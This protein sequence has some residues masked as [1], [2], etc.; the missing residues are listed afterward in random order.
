MHTVKLMIAGASSALFLLSGCGVGGPLAVRQG[1]Y[2]Y[3]ESIHDTSQEQ[4][5]LNIVRIHHQDSPFIMDVSE[6]DVQLQWQASITGGATGIGTASSGSASSGSGTTGASSGKSSPAG[7]GGVSG[8]L[9]G[10]LQYQESPTI[11]YMPLQ[12]APLIAQISSPITVDSLAQLINSDWAFLPILDMGTDRLANDFSLSYPALNAMSQLDYYGAIIVTAEKSAITSPLPQPIVQGGAG[13]PSP[14]GNSQ[15]PPNDCLAV[16]FEPDNP[17]VPNG[18]NPADLNVEI[19]ALWLRL[20]KIY[21]PSQQ[22]PF[23][24][25]NEKLPMRIEIR[26]ASVDVGKRDVKAT[27]APK[28]FAPPLQTRSALGVVRAGTQE[29]GEFI[30]FID[31]AVYPLIISHHYNKHADTFYTLEPRIE[32]DDSGD[33]KLAKQSIRNR[34]S[35]LDQS[36]SL[37]DSLLTCPDDNTLSEKRQVEERTLGYARRYIIILQSDDLPE[38]AFV[39]TFYRG[40]WYYIKDDDDISKKNLSLMSQFLTI[41]AIPSQGGALTPTLPVGGRSGG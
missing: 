26:R 17:L 24:I 33:V 16:Y 27:D 12:G 14:S 37:T 15:S 31:P 2:N 23:D 40:K 28:K 11:R 30:E 35:A 19:H 10:T 22:Q 41:Q 29:R 7:S 4:L 39:S 20:C 3:N 18:K 36:G 34:L 6:V 9:S 32:E 25:S 1:R 5:L 13:Q 38:G 8:S 21:A